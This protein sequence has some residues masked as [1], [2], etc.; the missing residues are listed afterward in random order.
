MGKK[1][2]QHYVPK[3]YLRNFANV[4]DQ[5]LSYDKIHSEGYLTNIR[6]TA[7]ERYYYNLPDEL[8]ERSKV[9]SNS[10]LDISSENNNQQEQVENSLACLEGLTKPIIDKLINVCRED[11][12]SKK[13]LILGSELDRVRLALFI[14]VQ[15]VRVPKYRQALYLFDEEI[16]RKSGEL[17]SSIN[18]SIYSDETL[19]LMNVS[20]ESVAREMQLAQLLDLNDGMVPFLFTNL[21]NWNWTFYSINIDASYL[22]SDNPVCIIA[23]PSVISLPILNYG[24]YVSFPLSHDVLITIY[25]K[26]GLFDNELVTNGRENKWRNRMIRTDDFKSGVRLVEEVNK[27]MCRI[28]HKKIF[29]HPKTNSQYIANLLVE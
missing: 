10:L 18:K 24:T 12:N 28:A 11:S 13:A 27:N 9:A 20:S 5:V 8:T 21:F 7:S 3:F 16:R 1:I 22:T 2:N 29:A 14:A 25:P 26:N 23:D 17:L 6:K 15:I 19:Q 4:K